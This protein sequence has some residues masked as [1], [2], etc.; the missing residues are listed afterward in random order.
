METSK[1]QNS[2][3]WY[4][5]T[6]FIK[7]QRTIQPC[8]SHSP[9]MVE[10]TPHTARISAFQRTAP[11]LKVPCCL[12]LTTCCR[13]MQRKISSI[14]IDFPSLVQHSAIKDIVLQSVHS[15]FHT[16]HTNSEQYSSWVFER[17]FQNW[18]KIFNQNF[19]Q[20]FLQKWFF[21]IG[22]N[23]GYNFGF[24][25]WFQCFSQKWLL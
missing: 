17:S 16:T 3:N 24:Q 8:N 2:K 5:Q 25:N 14:P 7:M 19:F 10:L 4:V 21:R 20:N 15:T 13:Q 1:Q 22:Y 11:S 12:L 9:Q 23:F 6:P 18:F